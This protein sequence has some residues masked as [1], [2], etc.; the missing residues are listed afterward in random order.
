MESIAR[1]QSRGFRRRG[2]SAGDA[3]PVQTRMHLEPVQR[4][5][6]VLGAPHA[7]IGAHAMAARGYPRFTVDIDLLTS[8]AHQ[9]SSEQG[10]DHG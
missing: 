5:L 9:P 8:D 6:Q 3:P 4:V 7:L 2:A 10:A 1:R